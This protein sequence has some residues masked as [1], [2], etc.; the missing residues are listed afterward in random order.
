[1]SA[2]SRDSVSEKALRRAVDECLLSENASPGSEELLRRYSASA[3]RCIL[4]RRDR[5]LLAEALR[6]DLFPAG[7]TARMAGEIPNLPFPLR[8]LLTHPDMADAVPPPSRNGEKA[9]SAMPVF[10]MPKAS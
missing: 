6:R 4:E 3:L 7:L 8:L 2:G 1:M 10:S 5:F 9:E